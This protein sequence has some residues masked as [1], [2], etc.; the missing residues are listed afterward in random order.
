[1]Q[2]HRPPDTR[3]QAQQ[4]QD[5]LTQMTAEVAIN[6]SW[7]G[8]GPGNFSTWLPQGPAP[9]LSLGGRGSAAP[10]LG[11]EYKSENN[12]HGKGHH[13]VSVYSSGSHCKPSG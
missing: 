7:E 5:L 13:L 10:P 2:A 4:A 3:T 8:G 12:E 1:M 11:G 9:S 6:E